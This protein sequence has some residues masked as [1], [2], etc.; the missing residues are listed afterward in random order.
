MMRLHCIP[1]PVKKVTRSIIKKTIQHAKNICFNYETSPECKS[2]WEL[3]D[4]LEKGLEKQEDS[5]ET[6]L[7]ESTANRDRS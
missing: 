7:S 6:R 4:E 2:A 3:V 1:K 5:L